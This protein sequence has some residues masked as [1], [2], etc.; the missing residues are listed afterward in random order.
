MRRRDLHGPFTKTEA[1]IR[2][3]WGP[4]EQ[5]V[6][7]LGHDSS[8]VTSTIVP[9]N[10]G[11]VPYVV[12]RSRRK[13]VAV[14]IRDDGSVEVRAPNRVSAAEIHRVVLGFRG[15]IERHR[16]AT[17]ARTARRAAR[18]FEDGEEFVVRGEPLVLRVRVVRDVGG[19]ARRV[20]DEL[21]VEVGELIPAAERAVHVRR[22]VMAWLLAA[23]ADWVDARHRELAPRV[24][25]SAVRIVLKDMRSRWGSCGP[26]RRMS[27]NWRLVLVPPDVL[28][29]VIVHELCHVFEPNHS[30][31][32]WERVEAVLPQA[33]QS[34]RWLRKHGDD[35]GF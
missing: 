3:I 10:C 11:P 18:R 7:G 34:R 24:G 29:Y 12:V 2:A 9:L 13:T 17:L 27:L 6:V 30:R 5:A 22:A 19:P 16:S 23:A 4:A 14:S 26:D 15:W 1:K 35:L 21:W 25:A 8:S 20:G 32:F 31:A 28:D 33:R